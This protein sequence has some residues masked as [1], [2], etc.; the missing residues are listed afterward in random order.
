[1]HKLYVLCRNIV[2]ISWHFY[3]RFKKQLFALVHMLFDC[4]HKIL[5]ELNQTNECNII[6]SKKIKNKTISS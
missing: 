4:K 6:K 5:S 2:T 1:M 3:D